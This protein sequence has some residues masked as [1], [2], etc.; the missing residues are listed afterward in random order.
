M[1]ALHVAC[2]VLLCVLSVV[3]AD[4]RSQAQKSGSSGSRIADSHTNTKGSTIK[5]AKNFAKAILSASGD[6][7]VG[8]DEKSKP[9]GQGFSLLDV[10][11][12]AGKFGGNKLIGVKVDSLDKKAAHEAATALPDSTVVIVIKEK[13]VLKPYSPPPKGKPSKRNSASSWSSSSS[14]SSSSGGSKRG[15]AFVELQE[16]LAKPKSSSSSSGRSS[17]SFSRSSSSGGSGS[18]GSSG[19]RSGEKPAN[20]FVYEQRGKTGLRGVNFDKKG[21]QFLDT[22]AQNRMRD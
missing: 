11:R 15:R 10:G 3:T 6:S 2:V 12:N 22:S 1:R 18:S 8:K 4:P 16:A 20:L 13:K 5:A 17:S 19:S 7:F 21:H 9:A 14:G